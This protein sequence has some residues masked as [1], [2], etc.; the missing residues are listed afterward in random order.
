M[1]GVSWEQFSQYLYIERKLD[2]SNDQSY[3]SR[4]RVIVNYFQNCPF[5][6]QGVN[7]FFSF[8][9]QRELRNQTLN[10]YLKLLKH[11]C[12]FQEL[13]F[14]DGYSY[15]KRQEIQYRILSTE[16]VKKLIACYIEYT[17][18]DSLTVNR[19]YQVAISTLCQTG[20]RIGELC[21]LQWDKGDVQ[22]D[23]IVIRPE[24]AKND[25]GREVYVTEK[26]YTDIC[27]LPKSLYV[28]GTERGKMLPATF[29]SELRRRAE[30]LGFKDWE[31]I[32]AHQLRHYFATE[33][34]CNR[35][36]PIEIVSK[37]LGHSDCGITSRIYSHV[38]LDDQKLI[39]ETNPLAIQ[40]MGFERVKEMIEQ[41]GNILSYTKYPTS[42]RREK[43]IIIL[44]SQDV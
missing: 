1:I 7:G 26:L 15:F 12:R 4:F 31:K 11:L 34:I 5:D 13:N 17:R 32:H 2:Q 29:N 16:E 36:M 9:I 39:I 21:A 8:L 20:L 22:P 6:K 44:Q 28:F 25:K 10:N 19:R 41:L 33:A 35:K 42:R 23:R 30:Y 3:R 18:C 14:L 24:I 43:D 27:S 38:S 40:G 37:I